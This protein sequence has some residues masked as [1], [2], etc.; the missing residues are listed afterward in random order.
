MRA[1]VEGRDRVPA[2]GVDLARDNRPGLARKELPDH[3]DPG[4][5]A[6]EGEAAS[7]CPAPD[8]TFCLPIM[9]RPALAAQ[10]HLQARP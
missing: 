2:G 4:V 8:L 10:P 6:T 3:S 7:R 1:T 9:P 5:T